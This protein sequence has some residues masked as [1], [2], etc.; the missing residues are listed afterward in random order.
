MWTVKTGVAPDFA[1]FSDLGTT[2]DRILNR[3]STIDDRYFRFAFQDRRSTLDIQVSVSMISP[4]FYCRSRRVTRVPVFQEKIC[5]VLGF[6]CRSRRYKGPRIPMED[7]RGVRVLLSL[8]AL[9]VSQDSNRR[10]AWC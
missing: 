2:I 3:R 5:V 6:Y 4:R 1:T 7:L 9:Q 8:K 10:F